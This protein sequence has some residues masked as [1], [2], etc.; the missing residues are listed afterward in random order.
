MKRK[1]FLSRLFAI[2]MAVS[3]PALFISC[4]KD[5]VDPNT[6]ENPDTP[7]TPGEENQEGGKLNVGDDTYQITEVTSNFAGSGDYLTLC[8]KL[9]TE[10]PNVYVNLFFH[11]SSIIPGEYPFGDFSSMQNGGCFAS[12][13]TPDFPDAARGLYRGAVTISDLSP[14]H[15]S[16]VGNCE[17]NNG[18]VV[19]FEYN[20]YVREL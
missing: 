14:D 15:Y 11:G 4:Q 20:G 3:V 19:S 2:L 7:D 17:T 1:L 6:P 18:Y 8:V 12:I 5:P 10:N 16:I 9:I 13:Y